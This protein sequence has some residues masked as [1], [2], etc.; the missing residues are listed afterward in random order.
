MEPSHDK[1]RLRKADDRIDPV[2]CIYDLLEHCFLSKVRTSAANDFGNDHI[3]IRINIQH[4]L[5][6]YCDVSYPSPL[7]ITDSVIRDIPALHPPPFN[8]P[9]QGASSFTGHEW[10]NFFHERARHLSKLPQKINHSP[11]SPALQ[12]EPD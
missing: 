12:R 4:S 6:P 9:W 8:G 2:R 1:D 5:D 7:D 3:P 10:A 11:A